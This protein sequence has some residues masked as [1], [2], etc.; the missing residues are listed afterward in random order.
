MTGGSRLSAA[1]EGGRGTISERKVSGLWAAF[2]CRPDSAPGP[3]NLF[4]ISFFFSFLFCFE[5]CLKI[6]NN[7]CL[8]L[9]HILKF[10]QLFFWYLKHT[11]KVFKSR[12]KQNLKR[13]CKCKMNGMH[14][15]MHDFM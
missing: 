15:M 11:G 13:M 14:D 4:P 10:V 9:G 5:F 12:T 8:N 2:G 1:E 7:F 3:F 6:A